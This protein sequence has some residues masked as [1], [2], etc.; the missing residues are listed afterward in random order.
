MTRATERWQDGMR[1]AADTGAVPPGPRR[2][3]WPLAVAAVVGTGAFVL[4][5]AASSGRGPGNRAWVDPDGPA[6]TSASTGP[7]V[8]PARRRSYTRN[9]SAEASAAAEPVAI[10]SDIAAAPEPLARPEPA[11]TGAIAPASHD[12]TRPAERPS[13]PALRST[14]RP[15]KRPTLR[16]ARLASEPAA[17]EPRPIR[18]A[19]ADARE[20]AGK[21]EAER[22]AS[23]ARA[24]RRTARAVAADTRSEWAVAVAPARVVSVCLYGV[25][26]F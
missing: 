9:A 20:G 13:S 14:E 5:V 2:C 19:P 16:H 1:Y 7:A 17:S 6:I 25:V 4:A 26:C 22:V 3:R 21:R 15:A 11:T 18:K 8:E 12:E 10:R 23:S 24:Q